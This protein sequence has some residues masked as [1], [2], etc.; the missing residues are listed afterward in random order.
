MTR[1]GKLGF[2][3]LIVVLGALRAV[4]GAPTPPQAP[5]LV[6][7][8]DRSVRFGTLPNGLRYAVKTNALPV[9]GL[10]IRLG[11]NVGSLDETED[12]RGAAHFIEHLAFG[13]GAG[14]K[15]GAA[16]AAAGVAFGQDRNAETRLYSTVYRIDIPH[17]D[18]DITSLGFRWLRAAADGADLSPGAVDHERAVILA[19]RSAAL[20]TDT[21]AVRRARSYFTPGQPYLERDP[22]G[23]LESLTAMTPQRLSRF[24]RAW[25]RPG[26]AV[27]VAVGD[28]SLD[29][30]EASVRSAFSSWAAAPT[31]APPPRVALDETATV[32][33]L[34][35]AEATAPTT[36][37]VCRVKSAPTAMDAAARFRREIFRRLWKAILETRL[38]AAIG[39]RD[40]SIASASVTTDWADRDV[41]GACVEAAASED[42]WAPALGRLKRE[43]SRMTDVDPSDAEAEAAVR[44]VRASFRGETQRAANRQSR[45]VATDITSALLTNDVLPAPAQAFAAFDDLV[46]DLTPADIRAAFLDA[47]SGAGPRILLRTP[48]AVAREDV[49]AAWSARSGPAASATSVATSATTSAAAMEETWRYADF[50]KAGK[51]VRREAFAAPDYVRLTFANG[52]VLNWM[53]TTYET[54]QAK[55]AVTFGAGRREIADADFAEAQLAALVFNLTGLGRHDVGAV[56]RLFAERQWGAE[57]SFGSHYFSL[58]GAADQRGLPA[59]LQLLAAYVSDPGYRNVDPLLSTVV[60]TLYRRYRTV[61]RLVADQAL[62]L[63]VSPDAPDVIPPRE[64]LARLRTSDIQRLFGPALA[65]APLRVAIV[66]DIDESTAIRA[67]AETFG[68]LPSRPPAP[69]PLSNPAFLRFPE[70]PPAPIEATHEGPPE[71]ALAELVWPLYVAEPARRREEYAL[72]LVAALLQDRL[73]HRLRDSLGKTYGPRVQTEM[74]DDAD[75]GVLRALV[76]TAPADVDMARREIVAAAG[77]MAAGTFTAEDLEAARAPLVSGWKQ[78]EQGNGLWLAAIS[79]TAAA[80]ATPRELAERRAVAMSLT[81]QEVRAVAARWLSRPP[82]VATVRPRPAA[83]RPGGPS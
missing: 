53:H 44:V 13:D 23:T 51:V 32:E 47:W 66:G 21:A 28:E 71:Q 20:T 22:I 30:L 73:L 41:S 16:F 4:A 59:E 68:A 37:I 3:A 74:V 19:E 10:S 48:V 40:A 60:T 52:V 38:T 75:Q 45:D 78:E 64:A 57:F 26:A 62:T 82:I 2:T 67:T 25:N 83:E 9:G 27:V 42:R 31:P 70:H 5:A 33:A 36:V 24:Y 58:K 72:N 76:E 6:L 55:V 12:E 17:A 63:A 43:L 35:D 80:E 54:G 79:A 46:A 61:P 39:D 8:W 11:V 1:A 34:V 81:L 14:G 7:A 50:G 49:I 56:K 15:T 65:A 29:A 77:S 18:A 69:R